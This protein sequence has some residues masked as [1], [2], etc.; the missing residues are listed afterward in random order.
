MRGTLRA[1]I[2]TA[3]VGLL[4]GCN[5]YEEAPK[6]ERPPYRYRLGPGDS[7][8]VSV[9]GRPELLTENDVGP[10]GR[11]AL[12]LAGVVPVAGL[13]LEETSDK[14]A[15]ALK[16]FVRDPIVT[17]ELRELRSQFVHVAGEVRVPGSVPYHDGMTLFEAIQ[18]SGSWVDEFGNKNRIFLVRDPVGAKRIFKLDLQEILQDPKGQKD[19][20]V[21]A[22]DIVFV[23]PRYV[24]EFARWIRQAMAPFDSLFGAGRS[25]AYVMSVP[26]PF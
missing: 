25:A 6:W 10:D 8:R 11:F 21:Q 12:P 15:A 13:T 20:L 4:A 19:V 3:V 1:A 14:L 17:V 9:W 26:R 24:T 5:S 22:G 16:E 2:A 23:P 7:L 18:R